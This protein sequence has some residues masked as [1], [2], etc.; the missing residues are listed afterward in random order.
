M[1]RI[2]NNVCDKVVKLADEETKKVV[3]NFKRRNETLGLN[4]NSPIKLQM[5]GTYQSIYIKSRH[6]MGQNASQAIGIACE[7]ET[8]SHDVIGF[9][10][11]N[12]LCWVGAWL[13]G[14][15]Y[16]VECP[17]HEHCTAK[18][19]RYDPLSE[20]DL[21]YEIGKKIATNDLLVDYCTTDG[22]AKSVKGLQE[23]MQ[24]IFGPLWSVN[25]LADTIHRGQSQFREGIRAKFSVGM[26]PGVTKAQKNDIKTAFANDIKLRS[27]G[28]M[29]SL[30]MK[31][32]GDRQKISKCLPGIVRS[33]VNCYS[34]NCGD[35]CRWSITL[36][37]GGKK[38]SWWY[39]SI[40]LNSHGLQNGSLIPTDRDKILIE[41]LLEMKLS[42]NALDQ[43]KFFSNTNKC[44]SVNRTISTY[45]PKNK[46]FSR[47]AI[48]RASAA[49][50]KVNNNK[51]VALVK[52]LKAVGCTMGKKS[53]A[54]V[55]LKKIRKLE[56]YDRAY[57]KSSKVKY[58]RD[59]K[60]NIITKIDA[61]TFEGLS[62][63]KELN[64]GKNKITRIDA[65]TFKGLSALTTLMLWD[66]KISTLDGNTFRGL[67]ALKALELS[68]NK[69][70]TLA[71]NIFQG[72]TALKTLNLNDN[73]IVTLDVNLFKGLT[74][75]TELNLSLNKI[76]TLAGNIFRGLAALKI[77]YLNGNKIV[78]LEV[79]LFKG[80]TALTE[81]KLE[82]NPLNCSMC[83]M[84][85]FKDFLQ[86]NNDFGN[87]GAR[88]KGEFNLLIHQNFI[89]CSPLG[90]IN[91]VVIFLRFHGKNFLIFI[92]FCIIVVRFLS[93]G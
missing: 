91:T 42:Q 35:T 17:N 77:L 53:R 24:E 28:I 37:N 79:N 5:D 60:N 23:A 33:V 3:E 86:R 21:G 41:S 70:S 2:T 4:K 59:L 88:C 31:Y 43:M 25:R 50:L 34:G 74:A 64:L 27:H 67:T 55:A 92:V 10:L 56:I 87:S 57:Q 15:G 62:T 46:N 73:H 36:C 84:K 49:V 81:L 68:M 45:L 52:T 8:D 39:K 93:M 65:N 30:F 6:K 40:N 63:L 13:R 11:V 72:L 71:V 14:E 32:N 69:I 44:E 51:D 82:N 26:F 58:R 85:E 22:D 19:N 66:N 76:S 80:L 1:Q 16:D 12:K 29:K 9:H 7:N 78:T 61:N 90:K 47:N 38:T 48:G 18:T 89:K 75:L 20:K 54:A 83:M